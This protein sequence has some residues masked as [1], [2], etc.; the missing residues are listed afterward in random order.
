MAVNP[1]GGES[2]PGDK[3]PG[4]VTPPLSNKTDLTSSNMESHDRI[5]NRDSPIGTLDGDEDEPEKIKKPKVNEKDEIF[6]DGQAENVD[7]EKVDCTDGIPFRRL[8]SN[9]KVPFRLEFCRKLLSW[10]LFCLH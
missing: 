6:D 7:V 3:N 8:D 1:L 5:V 9:D 10:S 4:K 2:V